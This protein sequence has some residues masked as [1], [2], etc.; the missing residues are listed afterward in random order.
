MNRR[1][2]AEFRAAIRK[3]RGLYSTP[4]ILAQALRLLRQPEV[5]LEQIEELVRRDSALVADLIR[6]SNSALFSRGGACSDLQL[7]LQRLGMRE[8][9]RAIGLSL[10]KNMFGKGLDNYGLPAEQYWRSSLLAAVLM[11]QLASMNGIDAPES[12]TVGILHSLGRVLINQVLEEL[13]VGERW[14]PGQNL[15]RW[16]VSQVGFTHAEAGALLLR[17][18]N[19]P[20]PIIAPIEHQL[21]PPSAVSAQT[22]SGMLRLVRLLLAA[23][24]D[25]EP[26]A[27]PPV[28]PPDLL[29]WAGFASDQEL[30][31]LLEEAE[32]KVKLIQD[33]LK[34]A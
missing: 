33:S 18:W 13:K 15:E 3:V 34:A 9:I 29:G 10:S 17:E 5:D 8:V 14:S 30:R 19:F 24:Q 21:G 1:T 26:A 6:L 31:D 20:N 22:P 4:E 25:G 28:F 23:G 7:A 11:E 12:Y 32:A 2:P 16:E 27:K